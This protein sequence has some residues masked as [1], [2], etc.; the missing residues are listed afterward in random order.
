[1]EISINAIREDDLEEIVALMRDFARYEDLSAYCTATADRLWTAIFGDGSFV[2]GL[3]ARDGEKP[4]G[5]ALFHPSFSSFR[6]ERGMY[7]EDIY[8][9]ANYRRHNLGHRMLQRIARR[10]N[11]LGF[12]RIDFMVLDWNRPAVDFYL[13]HGAE[14]NDDESHFKF[15]G[16]AFRAL[17]GV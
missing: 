9:D 5:Y 13:K 12:E 7:L 11:E 1:M 10:A 14:K 17:A 15:A 8:I 16:D 3:V 2:E 6:G 4:V